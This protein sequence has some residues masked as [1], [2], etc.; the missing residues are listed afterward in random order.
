MVG[1]CSEGHG[2]PVLELWGECSGDETPCAS[3]GRAYR[4]ACVGGAGCRV[5]HAGN[6]GWIG[7]ACWSRG[8]DSRGHD[9]AGDSLPASGRVRR[10]THRGLRLPRPDRAHISDESGGVRVDRSRRCFPASRLRLLGGADLP[11]AA[12]QGRSPVGGDH[13]HAGIPRDQSP[14]DRVN[15]LRVRLM[16]DCGCAYRAE[17][18]RRA[19]GGP[20]DAG[21]SSEHPARGSPRPRRGLVR[22]ASLARPATPSGGSCPT[23]WAVWPPRQRRRCSGRCLLCSQAC[24]RPVRWHS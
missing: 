14:G 16:G 15:V 8:D 19:V 7:P 12:A 20:V 13:S 18:H 2:P 23:C 10:R 6:P 24:P 9:P 22:M 5:G 4:R 1:E 11:F 21:F 17:H 3:L